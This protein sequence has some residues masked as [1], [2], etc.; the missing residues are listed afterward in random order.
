MYRREFYIGGR[1][2]PPTGTQR[3]EVISP[4][5]EMAVGEVPLAATGDIDRAVDAARA[6]FDSGR[7]PG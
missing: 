7:G 3:F 4:S 5:T 2:T 1:W 6:A